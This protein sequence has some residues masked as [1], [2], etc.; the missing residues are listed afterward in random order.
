MHLNHINLF[1]KTIFLW[2]EMT[3]FH[4]LLVLFS[5]QSFSFNL[6]KFHDKSVEKFKNIEQMMS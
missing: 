1:I 6:H 2:I 5:F 3:Y 4:L